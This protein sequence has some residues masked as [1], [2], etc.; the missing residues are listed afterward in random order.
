MASKM[1][2]QGTFNARFL[3]RT[4]SETRALILGNIA[5]HYG[6]SNDAALEEVSHDDAEHLLDY[7]TGPE[8][9][10]ASLIWRRHG[11]A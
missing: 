7:V 2:T 5:A 9:V 6:I 8:R 10:A 11:F 3:D 1:V 4:D